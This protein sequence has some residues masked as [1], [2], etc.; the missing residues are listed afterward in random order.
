[1]AYRYFR[2]L[3]L[4]CP[5][6]AGAAASIFM[7]RVTHCKSSERSVFVAPIDS[8]KSNTILSW[9]R[10][11]DIESDLSAKFGGRKVNIF[12]FGGEH[13]AAICEKGTFLRSNSIRSTDDVK[14]FRQYLVLERQ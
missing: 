7:S 14:F 9:G 11:R 8:A 10:G 2:L 3:S 12:A 5:A 4:S 6:A 13:S 1:M